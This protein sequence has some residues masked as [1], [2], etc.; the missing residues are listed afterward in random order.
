MEKNYSPPARRVNGDFSLYSLIVTN[1]NLSM[2]REIILDTETTGLDPFSG[3]RV[4]E[5][6]AVELIN[7]IP[8]G[9]HYHQY[10]NPER[11]MPPGAQAVHGLSSEFLRDK[12]VFAEICGD[13]MD[14]IGDSTLVIHNADFDMKFVNHHIK[15]LG[16]AAISMARV[17]D[18]LK[19]ARQKFPG[20]PASLDALCKR[21]N[22]DLSGR[23]L[24][25]ALLDSNL[26]AQVYLELIGGRQ[27]DLGLL[28]SAAA[29]GGGDTAVRQFRAPRPHAPNDAELESH[30]DMLRQIKNPLW[31]SGS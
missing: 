23:T 26:L 2:K 14:F 21:F 7:H 20:A 27:A 5:I 30:A 18:T 31:G 12:P 17:I 19:M 28:A 4:V 24:H 3:D 9:R 16:F 10:I 11:D 13:F 29:G 22:V 25:G 15:D 1:Y 6:G 8:T